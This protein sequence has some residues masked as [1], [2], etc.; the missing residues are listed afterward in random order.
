MLSSFW[1][2]CS[3]A[4][5]MAS[6]AG[7]YGMVAAA[8]MVCG[9]AWTRCACWKVPPMRVEP[10]APE[11][12]L[13]FWSCEMSSTLPVL[14]SACRS[15][16]PLGVVTVCVTVRNASGMDANAVP[17]EAIWPMGNFLA[18]ERSTG[19][20]TGASVMCVFASCSRTS[21]LRS[22]SFAGW[23]DS[24]AMAAPWV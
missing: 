16:P 19:S 21:A 1:F 17:I 6:V 18:R 4:I 15:V 11:P 12:S 14:S 5:A 9:P 23:M 24:S 13:N 2:T 20:S 3:R 8:V 22:S 7:S 10:S